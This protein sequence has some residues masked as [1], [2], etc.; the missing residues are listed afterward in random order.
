MIEKEKG[1]RKIKK[2][3]NKGKTKLPYDAGGDFLEF[4]SRGSV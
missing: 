3:K 4:K 1:K 2:G